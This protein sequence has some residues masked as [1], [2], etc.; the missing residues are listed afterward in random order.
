MSSRA[1]RIIG[2]L[3]VLALSAG[4]LAAQPD[5]HEV[6]IE[7]SWTIVAAPTAAHRCVSPEPGKARWKIAVVGDFPMLE[8]SLSRFLGETCEADCTHELRVTVLPTWLDR[9]SWGTG[10]GHLDIPMTIDRATGE[11]RDQTRL[12]LDVTVDEGVRGTAAVSEFHAGRMVGN[13]LRDMHARGTERL[14]RATIGST[15]LPVAATP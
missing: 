11:C 5:E 14:A 13:G 7:S 6:V 1:K 9:P 12:R 3:A 2:L 15:E 4:I 8:R 10:F